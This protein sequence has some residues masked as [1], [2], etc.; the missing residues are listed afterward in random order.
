MTSDD[1]ILEIQHNKNRLQRSRFPNEEL[2][3]AVKKTPFSRVRVIRFPLETGEIEYLI[4]NIED[5]TYAEIVELYRMRWGIETVYF[6]L[7]QKLQIEKFTSSIPLLIEQD[8]RSGVLAYNIIQSI[9]REAEE[10]IDQ[11]Q[12]KHNMKA[13][14]NMAIGFVKKALILILINEDSNK[15][16]QMYDS[17]VGRIARFK[18]PI[19]NDRHFPIRFKTDNNNSFNKLNSY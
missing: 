5:F 7:K 12:Y 3:Q 14:E 11:S 8:I 19:R 1:E 9:K 4:T 2:F 6:S 15:R 18:I 17:M 16:R 10:T 13:N